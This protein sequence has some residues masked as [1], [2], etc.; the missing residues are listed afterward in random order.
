MKDFIT[1]AK[2]TTKTL[3]MFGLN[4]KAIEV[5]H[6]TARIKARVGG[7]ELAIKYQDG[8]ITFKVS[9]AAEFAANDSTAEFYR[10]VASVTTPGIVRCLQ[11][12]AADLCL[13]AP[14]SESAPLTEYY[15]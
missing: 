5:L 8:G 7:N 6:K 4:L 13:C 14:S 3:A 1:V 15:L 12:L 10:A 9:G 11:G 2:D